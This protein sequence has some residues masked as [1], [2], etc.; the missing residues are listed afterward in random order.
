MNLKEIVLDKIIEQGTLPLFFH[1]DKAESIEILQTLYRAG[2][3]VFEFTNRGPEALAVFERLIATRDLEMP[4]LYLGIGTIKSVDE[5]QQFLQIGA[6]FIVSPIVNPL[7]GSL[8]HEQHKLWIPGCMTPTEI[9]TAQQQEAALIKLFPANILGPAFMS[10]I[11]DLFKGQ[12]FMPTG[13]VEIEME[14]LKAWFKSGVCAV[15]MGSKLIDPKNTVNLFEN[16]K[17]AL[18][19]VSKAR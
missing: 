3:R 14:N 11:R 12:K 8:V 19:F 9:Y 5:A 15:G 6:D 16:T 1:H 2:I 17:K 10:S 7:V 13:G 18:D 4:D